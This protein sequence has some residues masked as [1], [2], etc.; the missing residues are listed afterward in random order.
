MST[1]FTFGCSFTED[2][3]RVIETTKYSD[4]IPAQRRYVENHLNGRIPKSW[5]QLLSEKLDLYLKN[6]G[7][8]GM[9]NY[10][11]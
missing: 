1:L 2:F 8:G 10:H 11:I 9:S 6:Y 3:E 7:V 4:F 5:P